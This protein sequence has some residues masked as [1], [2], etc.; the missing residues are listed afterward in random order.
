MCG[1]CM[2]RKKGKDASSQI[3]HNWAKF[4]YSFHISTPFLNSSGPGLGR[5]R[6]ES[7]IEDEVALGSEKRARQAWS[8]KSA[9]KRLNSIEMACSIG[10]DTR[11]P[12]A[13]RLTY[14][15][16]TLSLRAIRLNRPRHTACALVP[17]NALLLL[18]FI[19]L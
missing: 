5:N 6:Q 1:L 17:F 3:S 7:S 19:L 15:G 4:Q 9:A 16:S 8:A 18:R 2:R 14:E 12:L 13:T 11:S 10:R